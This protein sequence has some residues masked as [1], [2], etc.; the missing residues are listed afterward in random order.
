MWQRLVLMFKANKKRE[1]DLS[2][3]QLRLHCTA[4]VSAGSNNHKEET[5][6]IHPD[7]STYFKHSFK[8]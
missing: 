1:K 2:F 3:T 8:Y 4:E 5:Q 6:D 7:I